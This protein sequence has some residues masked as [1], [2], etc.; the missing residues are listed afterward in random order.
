MRKEVNDGRFV[1]EIGVSMAVERLLRA[2]YHVARPV[3]DD[4]YDLVAFLGRRHWRIQVKAT[5]TR[6]RNRSRIRIRRG[7]KKATPYSPK[8]VDAFVLVHTGTG[9]VLCVPVAHAKGSWFPFRSIDTYA[10]FGILR[11]IES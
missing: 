6:G 7:S 1:A 2:G 3:V 5:A 9:A 11:S 8:H 4:G 10:D